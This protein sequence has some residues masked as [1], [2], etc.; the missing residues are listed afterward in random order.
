MELA[1]AIPV[2][3]QA[4][5]GVLQA[6]RPQAQI[7]PQTLQAPGS[8]GPLSFAG[9]LRALQLD[10]ASDGDELPPAGN[11]LPLTAV[12]EAPWPP[13]SLLLPVLPLPPQE[14]ALDTHA[15][16]PSG[17][18]TGDSVDVLADIPEP[19]V[20]LQRTKNLTLPLPTT[21]PLPIETVEL[22]V[23]ERDDAPVPAVPADPRAVLDSR[24][25]RMLE[26]V[27]ARP[28]PPPSTVAPIPDEL[29]A[30]S[31]ATMLSTLPAAASSSPV[32]AD[33]A[34]LTPDH[35]VNVVAPG[36]QVASESGP[37]TA[38]PTIAPVPVPSLSAASAPE[39]AA[40]APATPPPQP[41]PIDLAGADGA[42]QLAA[43]IRWIVD[44]N[45]GEA[46]LTLH[47]P[48]LGALDIKISLVD[49]KTFVQVVSHHAA[50]RDLIEQ[51]LPRLREM[52][53]AVG[54]EI[55]GASV[56]DGR[57]DGRGTGFVAGAPPEPAPLDFP[58][59]PESRTPEPVPVGQIDV[60]A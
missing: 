30:Q 51:T 17:P 48:E 25:L 34:S 42:D 18:G 21:T 45:L 20:L 58:I 39:I 5:F 26:A 56:S 1:A 24:S 41:R 37:P 8:G 40:A 57:G 60:Y 6:A 23:P 27:P 35:S 11:P 10:D 50:A 38:G 52:L 7:L 55:G 16:L 59:E 12:L 15:F 44:R 54:L 49:D 22:A 3:L 14:V 47:P 29:P 2:D 4:A 9:T 32:G 13:L 28:L 53:S 46:R 43:R 31:G 36:S 19:L 33:G